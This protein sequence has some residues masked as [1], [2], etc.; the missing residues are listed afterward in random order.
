MQRSAERPVSILYF[1]PPPKRFVCGAGFLSLPRLSCHS[2][3]RWEVVSVCRLPVGVQAVF[4]KTITLFYLSERILC[5]K[6]IWLCQ[7]I[8]GILG[9]KG[10]NVQEE[11]LNNSS[12][13]ALN[14][15]IRQAL[16]I[17]FQMHKRTHHGYACWVPR[18]SI[19]FA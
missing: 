15:W 18:I 11:K 16:N 6:K 12:A 13:V 3:S 9:L 17:H 19:I 1:S 4:S 8:W 7:H 10:P 2:S 5:Y 14:A